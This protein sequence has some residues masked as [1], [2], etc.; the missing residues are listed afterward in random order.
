LQYFYRHLI[1]RT[2]GLLCLLKR[3]ELRQT[4]SSKIKSYFVIACTK[5]LWYKS[6]NQSEYHSISA[7]MS[8]RNTAYRPLF[9][10][11]SPIVWI[12]FSITWINIRNSLQT[13]HIGFNTVT[14]FKCE[15][16]PLCA[17]YIMVEQW[18]VP[19]F[20]NLRP[21][22]AKSIVYVITL[23]TNRKHAFHCLN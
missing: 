15:T 5:W 17:H 4:C 20:L 3:P 2:S 10:S 23:I 12:N 16:L 18:I 21:K 22:M 14:V 7:N 6:F 9:N 13:T 8:T 19:Q 1:Y 11:S